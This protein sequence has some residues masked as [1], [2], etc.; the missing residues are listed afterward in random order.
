MR[1]AISGVLVGIAGVAGVVLRVGAG[2]AELNLVFPRQAL[3]VAI[4]TRVID[5]QI[6]F[7]IDVSNSGAL[8]NHRMVEVQIRSIPLEYLIPIGNTSREDGMDWRW[9]NSD[10][11]VTIVLTNSSPIFPRQPGISRWWLGKP[12]PPH[13]SVMQLSVHLWTDRGA[14]RTQDFGMLLMHGIENVITVR[15]G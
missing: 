10:D 15:P 11:Q 1:L 12:A 6:E 4:T 5:D 3:A 8:I 9:E 13:G 14:P 7:G 2:L